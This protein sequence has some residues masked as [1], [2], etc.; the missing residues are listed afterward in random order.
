MTN[1][2]SSKPPLE[3]LSHELLLLDH[4]HFEQRCRDRRS[5]YVAMPTTDVK[6]GPDKPRL[7]GYNN[8]ATR[9]HVRQQWPRH[10]IDFTSRFAKSNVVSGN[11]K[12]LSKTI[13]AY[14]YDVI[15]EML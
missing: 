13:A 4:R 11:R 7:F 5:P 6:I 2:F 14:R 3:R 10:A 8:L 12:D 9:R 15:P 1:L